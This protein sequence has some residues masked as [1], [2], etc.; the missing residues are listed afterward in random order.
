MKIGILTFHRAHNYGAVLQCYALQTFLCNQGHEAKVIDYDSPSLWKFYDWY[1]PE[2]VRH[3]FSHLGKVLKRCV[4]LIITWY[5]R[6]PRYYKFSGF[7]NKRLNLCPPSEIIHS[8]F[9]LV[10]IGSDQ[11]WN[12]IITH[13]FDPYYWGQFTRPVHTK[14]ATYAASLIGEWKKSDLPKIHDYLCS[15]DAVSVREDSVARTLVA[16]FPGINPVVVPDPVILVSDE[17]WERLAISPKINEPYIFFYQAMDSEGAYEMARRIARKCGK[18]LVVLSANV[19]GR[20]S[21]ECRNASPLEFVGWI[22]N[23]DVVVTSSFHATVF[24][25]V[26]RKVFY[27]ID[28][29]LERDSRLMDLLDRFELKSR[30]VHSIDDVVLSP[31]DKYDCHDRIQ[32]YHLTATQY[33]ASTLGFA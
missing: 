21:N 32:T 6:I 15:L 9:D 13:G 16:L 12:T 27:C 22:K 19:N 11:V 23:A 25:I 28:L 14:V 24:S 17:E 18:R 5:H 3:A 30:L 8:P 31:E 7:Q 29:E 2:E 26:F 33:I 1:K 4:K 20:N 10:L